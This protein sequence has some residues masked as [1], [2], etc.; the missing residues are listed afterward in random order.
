MK[1]TV[2]FPS[3]DYTMTF[4]KKGE[5]EY[6]VA[7]KNVNDNL[8]QLAIPIN[9][10]DDLS[11]DYIND[12]CDLGDSLFFFNGKPVREDGQIYK[13]SVYDL[14]ID[15]SLI[16]YEE[17]EE[18][19]L[20]LVSHELNNGFNSEKCDLIPLVKDNAQ[21]NNEY[22]GVVDCFLANSHGKGQWISLPLSENEFKQVCHNLH[23]T[24]EKE[25]NIE[26]FNLSDD[27]KKYDAFI[28]Y[29]DDLDKLNYFAFKL[30]E[31]REQQHSYGLKQLDIHKSLVDEK[32]TSLDEFLCYAQPEV[33]EKLTVYPGVSCTEELGRQIAIKNGLTEAELDNIDLRD[34]GYK[35]RLSD[36]GFFTEYGYLSDTIDVSNVF[37]K[38][39]IPDELLITP[40]AIAERS[41]AKSITMNNTAVNDF[42]ELINKGENV[43]TRNINE[44]NKKKGMGR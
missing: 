42:K 13:Q 28:H 3:S 33:L 27:L 17:A 26:Q 34:L 2:N 29:D 43:Q 30:G 21:I 4:Q 7:S 14:F 19:F 15:C 32:L 18:K 37:S 39:L 31:M 24:S 20:T 36:D 6:L 11:F 8:Y 44:K 25:L 16:D 12:E 38:S 23:V 10:N 35:H 40:E 1:Q 9:V 41:K 22:K 5:S